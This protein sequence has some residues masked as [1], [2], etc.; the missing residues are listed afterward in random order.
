MEEG[1]TTLRI[2]DCFSKQNQVKACESLAAKLLQNLHAHNTQL[3]VFNAQM[4]RSILH[5]LSVLLHFLL[6][7]YWL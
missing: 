5:R 7:I 3:I 2:D 1:G 4:F 6:S